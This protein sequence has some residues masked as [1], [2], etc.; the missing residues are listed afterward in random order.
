MLIFSKLN[1]IIKGK[2]KPKKQRKKETVSVNIK[3]AQF[4]NYLQIEGN[5]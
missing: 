4:L 3:I 1:A 2:K 5:F